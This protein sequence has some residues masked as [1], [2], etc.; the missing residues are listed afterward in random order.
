MTGNPV[1]PP[2]GE[3]SESSRPPP[4]RRISPS[5]GQ[6]PLFPVTLARGAP[7]TTLSG[8]DPRRGGV[9]APPVRPDHAA[10]HDDCTVRNGHATGDDAAHLKGL[11]R[12]FRDADGARVADVTGVL[13]VIMIGLFLTLYGSLLPHSRHSRRWPPRS[14]TF[15][16]VLAHPCRLSGSRSPSCLRCCQPSTIQLNQSPLFAINE[17]ECIGIVRFGPESLEDQ[18]LCGTTEDRPSRTTALRS[19]PS[20]SIHRGLHR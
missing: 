8:G 13:G 1:T 6:D 15:R 11:R 14:H 12:K 4:N 20:E 3:L 18:Y 2:S 7:V 17:P 16:W 19:N 9:A 5:P 10:G